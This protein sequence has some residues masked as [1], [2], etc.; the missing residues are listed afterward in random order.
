MSIEGGGSFRE[1]L[2]RRKNLAKY[3]NSVPSRIGG[4]MAPMNFEDVAKK[5]NTTAAN[6]ATVV[7]GQKQEANKAFNAG[8]L[9][10]VAL[11]GLIN[12]TISERKIDLSGARGLEGLRSNAPNE[13][14]GR[15]AG[16][17]K[18]SQRSGND[19]ISSVGTANWSKRAEGSTPIGDIIRAVASEGKRDP[20]GFSQNTLLGLLASFS[21]IASDAVGSDENVMAEALKKRPELLGLISPMLGTGNVR[22]NVMAAEQPGML[23]SEANALDVADAASWLIPGLGFTKPAQVAGRAARATGRGIKQSIDD[24]AV[25]G[26]TPGPR[27]VTDTYKGYR[28]IDKD[29]ALADLRQTEWKPGS[30]QEVTSTGEL[31]EK[32]NWGPYD[33]PVDPRLA[34]RNDVTLIDKEDLTPDDIAMMDPETLDL[35]KVQQTLKQNDK[36]ASAQMRGLN[37]PVRVRVQKYPTWEEFRSR[38]SGPRLGGVDLQSKRELYDDAIRLI[39]ETDSYWRAVDAETGK[40]VGGMDV[41]HRQHFKQGGRGLDTEG[42]PNVEPQPRGPNRSQGAQGVGGAEGFANWWKANEK[43]ASNRA[44]LEAI[45]Y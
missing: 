18:A 2:L 5:Y 4:R 9:R 44:I 29:Q 36:Q 35:L 17:E 42:N 28:I 20:R 27:K 34:G 6:I 33:R 31:L 13:R 38:L 32:I 10:S 23:R 30:T 21:N 40:S 8:Y 1:G 25:M 19:I 14:M 45:F 16:A 43:T 15:F 12:P 37:E 3:K 7:R 41:A 22:G 26:I 39:D 24:A 11:E